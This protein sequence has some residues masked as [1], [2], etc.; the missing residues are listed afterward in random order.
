MLSRQ[1]RN[2]C[3]LLSMA[4]DGVLETHTLRGAHCFR[5][6]LSA[7]LIH[8]PWRKTT[9]SNRTPEGAICFP[10]SARPSLDHLPRFPYTRDSSPAMRRRSTD[11]VLWAASAFLAV[12]RGLAPQCRNTHLFSRQRQTYVCF[13][14]Q[15]ALRALYKR[16]MPVQVVVPLLWNGRPSVFDTEHVRR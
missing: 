7:S 2:L 5:N 1:V 13:T 9:E 3:D 8:L 11:A 10:S 12:G 15:G 14:Y 6:R 4:V 16:S